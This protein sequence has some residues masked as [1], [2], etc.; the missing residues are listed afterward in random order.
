MTKDETVVESPDRLGWSAHGVVAQRMQPT[1]VDNQR[2][3]SEPG[4]D[5]PAA[6][7][8]DGRV[9]AACCATMR[10][11]H[12]AWEALDLCVPSL[13]ESVAKH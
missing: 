10:W 13:S 11:A 1:G 9:T 6:G 4:D 3:I 5:G 8:N 7:F 2:A 12:C